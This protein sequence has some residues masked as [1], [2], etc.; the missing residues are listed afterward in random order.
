MKKILIASTNVGKI[1]V[2]S[3]IFKRLGLETIS[4]REL[5]VDIKV[6]ENG[7]DEL[8]NAIIKAKAYNEFT[9]LPVFANDSGLIIDKLKPE[10][11]PGQFVRRF[12][13]KELTDEELLNLYIEKLNSVGGES[14]GH[15]NVGL[16]LIDEKGQIYSKMFYP[17]RY[18]INK[19]SAIVNK[20]VPLNSITYDFKRKKYMSEM[21]PDEK[22]DY[23]EKDM[24]EQEIF[25]RSIFN[26]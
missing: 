12:K 3:V 20:G 22:I 4:L 26:K 7:K 23:E 25:I 21:P 6:E 11:Q 24:D 15:F 8:E 17:K 10:D 14:S 16:A 2:Y 9:G 19:P 5:S 13:G 1:A 18:F